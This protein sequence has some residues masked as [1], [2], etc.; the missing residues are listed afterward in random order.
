MV[1]KTRP[2]RLHRARRE[3]RAPA[4]PL[5]CFGWDGSGVSGLRAAGPG[6][7]APGGQVGADAREPAGGV[8]E[9]VGELPGADEVEGLVE[10]VGAGNR[11]QEKNG[12]EK[13]GQEERPPE[14]L[15][16]RRRRF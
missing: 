1:A 11:G 4:G 2:S 10:L 12:Q 9:H 3:W 15:L 8:Q 14:K 6:E 13:N 7:A 16:F 5:P